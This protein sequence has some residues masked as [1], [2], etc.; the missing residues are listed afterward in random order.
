MPFIQ[1]VGGHAGHCRDEYSLCLTCNLD[2]SEATRQEKVQI[3]TQI[4]CA[5]I[6]NPQ[7]KTDP[8]TLLHARQLEAA[9]EKCMILAEST[10]HCIISGNGAMAT[11][12]QL[13][14]A[15]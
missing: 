6:E 13:L 15:V 8:C 9:V 14:K 3:A 1:W 7:V 12:V 11:K 5:A 10:L 2:I 4:G